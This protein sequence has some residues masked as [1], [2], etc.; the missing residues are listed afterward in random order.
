[1]ANA[2]SLF[3]S[4]FTGGLF[5]KST[6]TKKRSF[7]PNLLILDARI[8]PASVNLSGATGWTPIMI[9]ATKDYANDS[10]AGAADTDT[11]HSM[12]TILQVLRMIPWCFA[13]GSTTQLAQLI[14]QVLQLWV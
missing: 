7:R 4:F 2:F 1:M 8:N 5:A 9:G 3:R 6:K 13:C 11:P 10:Q 14:L 12:I